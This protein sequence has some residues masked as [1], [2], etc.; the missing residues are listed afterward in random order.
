[1]L[2]AAIAA[3]A[4]STAKQKPKPA[5][6]KSAK[7]QT[8]TKTAEKAPRQETT[9]KPELASNEQF[10]KDE[11]AHFDLP[12]EQWTLCGRLRARDGSPYLF[13]AIYNKAGEMFL[14]ARNGYNTLRLPD[15]RYDYRAYGQGLVRTLV[16]NMFKDKAKSYPDQPYFAEMGARLEA[17]DTEHFET[18]PD[19]HYVIYR[20]QLFNSFGKNVFERVSKSDFSYGLDLNTWAGLMKLSLKSEADPMYFDAQHPMIVDSASGGSNIGML[21]GYMF[22]RLKAVGAISIDGNEIELNGDVWFDHLFGRPDGAA[23]SFIT[24]ISLRLSNGGDLFIANFYGADGSLK[25][26][27]SLMRKPDGTIVRGKKVD[28][29]PLRQWHS[30]KTYT[31]YDIAW[32]LSGA[33][34]EG[35]VWPDPGAED[36]EVMLEDGI[37]G[38]WL[39]PCGFKGRISWMGGELTGEGFCRSVS[40]KEK[41]ID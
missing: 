13:T 17:S 14:Q 8:T 3:G 20:G 4:A 7:K 6:A 29:R 23:M 30:K 15:G 41:R 36:S 40:T 9:G 24:F 22:P 18:L 39:G 5:P 31:V 26:R 37:G 27:N 1:M 38:F 19:E 25:N 28:L 32:M 35:R 34:V 33:G 12:Y 16:S 10:Y 21:Q 11:G 2:T